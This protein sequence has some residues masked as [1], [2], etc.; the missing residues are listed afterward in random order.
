MILCTITK[1][2]RSMYVDNKMQEINMLIRNNRIAKYFDLP[3]D[4]QDQYL[5]FG[6]S[7]ML[8]LW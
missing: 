8:Q 5:Y 2:C 6:L 1:A 4:F 3:W 7:Y